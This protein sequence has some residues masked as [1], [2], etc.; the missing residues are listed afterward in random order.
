MYNKYLVSEFSCGQ[1][2]FTL[3]H[4]QDFQWQNE[5]FQNSLM[6]ALNRGYCMFSVHREKSLVLHFFKSLLNTYLVT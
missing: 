3:A 2:Q 4:S 1:I 5:K 6:T